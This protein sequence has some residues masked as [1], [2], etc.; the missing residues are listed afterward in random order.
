ML[1]TILIGNTQTYYFKHLM[2]TPRGYRG[3]YDLEKK[4]GD[5]SGMKVKAADVKA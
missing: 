5:L 2:V 4:G 1:T 3:K